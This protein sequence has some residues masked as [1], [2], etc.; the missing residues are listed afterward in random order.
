MDIS[1]DGVIYIRNT[2]MLI[3]EISHHFA[4]NFLA[5]TVLALMTVC[6]LLSCCHVYF[7]THLCQAILLKSQ[8]V[9]KNTIFI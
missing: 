6:L 5:P 1:I 8:M 9:L 4:S 7:G 2:N 3:Y